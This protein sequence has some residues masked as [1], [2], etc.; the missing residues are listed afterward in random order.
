MGALYQRGVDLKTEATVMVL[1]GEPGEE[2]LA[3]MTELRMET[4]ALIVAV[5]LTNAFR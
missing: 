4:G 3:T 1:A 5:Y 2:D